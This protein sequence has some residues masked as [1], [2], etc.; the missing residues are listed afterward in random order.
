MTAK[1]LTILGLAAASLAACSSDVEPFNRLSK[2]RVLALRSEPPLP[3]TGETA[4]LTALV[5]TPAD[6]PVVSYAW[7]WCP[8][9][10]S[11]NE[12]YPCLVTEAQVAAVAGQAGASVPPFDLGSGATAMLPNS[13]DP[14]ILQRLCAGVLGEL[15]PPDCTF[16][17]PALVRLEVATAR[18]RVVAVATL[19]LRFDPA[20]PGNQNPHIDGLAAMPPGADAPQALGDEPT[21]TLPRN[22]D[23]PLTATVPPEVA[24]S[25]PGTDAA[26]NS[27]SVRER[28]TLSWFVESGDVHDGRTGF[29]DGVT[30][31]ESALTTKWKPGLTKDYPRDTSRLLVVIR[32]N[33]GG[34]GWRSAAVQL[35]ADQ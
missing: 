35:G 20:V 18:D 3:A 1:S 17:Y 23:T 19:P 11:A 21:V 15:N 12:G 4:T 6:D 8:A 29:I 25:Y 10:G 7:S 5:Y 27:G 32:D 13:V 24:E 30:T 2:L 31:F 14:G 26:G 22:V 9:P 33:R 28:I 34:V 16:G